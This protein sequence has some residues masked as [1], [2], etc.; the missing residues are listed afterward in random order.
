MEPI[1]I[2]LLGIGFIGKVHFDT[3]LKLP[4][5]K[6]TA[7]CDIDPLKRGGR[8][9][10][11]LDGAEIVAD[12]TDMKVYAEAA[13][14]FADP[15]VDVVD[16][17]LPTYLHA[18]YTVAAF[19][20]GKHVICEKPMA[21]ASA[22]CDTMISAAKSAGRRLYIAHCIRFWPCYEKAREIVLGGAWGRVHTARFRRTSALPT[23]SWE[24]W[25][26][27]SAKS[28]LCALDFHI[29]D[30]DFVHYLFGMPKSVTSLGGGYTPDRLDHIITAYEYEAGQLITA[31]GG[32]EHAPAY[33]F[34][35]TFTI[36]MEKATLALGRDGKLTL[37][38]KEGAP[39]DIQIP[40]GDGY[41]AEFRHFFT[42]LQKDADSSVVP[43][44][45][46]RDTLRL[47]E[48]EIQAAKTKKTVHI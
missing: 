39:Q 48:A 47:I 22:E 9:P 18:E 6:L 24:G 10:S 2:G 27:D 8:W 28:G 16:I 23:W 44:Q 7:V 35:M 31:E 12:Y 20:A 4:E 43:P 25:L 40:P 1:R 13:R 45:S 42:C 36:V 17:A 37:Y 14:L 33:P 26:Q 46:A 38:P 15:E 3:L 30:A 41:E 21:R 5:A 19:E 32:W 29:H 34:S 11:P